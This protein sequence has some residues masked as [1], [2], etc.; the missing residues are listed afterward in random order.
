MSRM[1]QPV[2]DSR[3]YLHGGGTVDL[4]KQEAMRTILVGSPILF[5]AEDTADGIQGSGIYTP[6]FGSGDTD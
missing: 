1:D 3:Q 2:S 5:E 6:P 4:S